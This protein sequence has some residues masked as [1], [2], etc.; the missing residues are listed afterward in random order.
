M[1]QLFFGSDGVGSDFLRPIA[2]VTNTQIPQCS[3]QRSVVEL[4][5]A[6]ALLLRSS[7]DGRGIGRGLYLGA[8]RPE[9]LKFG[10]ELG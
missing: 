9:S 7:C 1:G 2:G 10:F 6:K 8:L 3:Q 4:S 5:L